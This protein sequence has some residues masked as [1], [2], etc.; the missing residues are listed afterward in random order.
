MPTCCGRF[1][2]KTGKL[3]CY[4]S[5]SSFSHRLAVEFDG[6]RNEYTVLPR[7]GEI[8]A[9]YKNWSPKIKHSDLEN[10]EYD[11]VEV[12][13]QN[14]LQIKVSLLERV[15]GFNSVFKTKLTGLTALTQELLCTELIRFS[16][17]IPTCQLTEER[18]GSLR[19]FWE[20]DPAALPI[21]YFDLT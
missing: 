1:K 7:K 14:D 8:W 15:S 4:S 17:Q 10:C 19:G 3:K 9:L 21:H 2:A 16:H 12:L 11:V 18:G 5:T 6:K 13:D 20:L